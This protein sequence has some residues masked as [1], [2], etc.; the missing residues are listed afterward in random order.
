MKDLAETDSR[1]FTQTPDASE[2]QTRRINE[3]QVA[4]R[5]GSYEQRVDGDRLQEIRDYYRNIP[6]KKFT[7]S[8]AGTILP[9]PMEGVQRQEPL[10]PKFVKARRDLPRLMDFIDAVALY[11]HTD[12]MILENEYPQK[13]LVAPAD[14]WYGFKIFGEE[15]IMSA[16]NLRPLDRKILKFLRG[17]PGHKYSAMEIQSKM[18]EPEYGENRGISEIRNALEDMIE[19]MYLERHDDSPIQF[20][21]STFGKTI[22]VAN[23]AK[24]DWSHVVEKAKEKAHDNLTPEQAEQYIKTHCEGSGLIVTHPISGE[25][26]NILEDTEYDDE[27]D[28]AQEEVDEVMSEPMDTDWRDVRHLADK[29]PNPA[30]T[31][32]GEATN[33][34]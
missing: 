7:E 15:L 8:S 18:S 11:H 33:R 17:R 14:V 3:R 24:L 25:T 10:P 34:K 6:I 23:Q 21:A 9:L 1:A 13:L 20:S 16:L 32:G 28:Q 2:E 29:Q 31:D 26:V 12:R 4:M 27:L 22:D 19:K 30:T 5:D